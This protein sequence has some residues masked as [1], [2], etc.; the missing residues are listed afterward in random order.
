MTTTT[1]NIL[2]IGAATGLSLGLLCFS[3]IFI[4]HLFGEM[5]LG[6]FQLAFT[7]PFFF[8][9]FAGGVYIFREYKNSGMASV[10][11]AF[12]VCLLATVAAS[13]VF[14]LGVYIFFEQNKP[15]FEAHKAMLFEFYNR[16]AQELGKELGAA[17]TQTLKDNLA[18]TTAA[19][20]AQH[21]SFKFLGIGLMF[22]LIVGLAF[23][24]RPVVTIVRK[25][26]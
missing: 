1:K 15:V 9:C 14:G 24:K 13:L 20:I 21:E 2:W 19:S 22:T 3:G 4:T 17:E 8:G 12:T 10:R 26:E 18:Q 5:P 11:E 6:R 23:K 7:L 16:A 25:E